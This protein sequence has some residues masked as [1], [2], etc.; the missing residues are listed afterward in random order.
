MRANCYQTAPTRWHMSYARV[1]TG[2]IFI[3][4]HQHDSGE[5]SHC[6][7]LLSFVQCMAIV[8]FLFLGQETNGGERKPV[9]IPGPASGFV[10]IT[11]IESRLST[12]THLTGGTG[13]SRDRPC[14]EGVSILGN[15]ALPPRYPLGQDGAG[16]SRR[17]GSQR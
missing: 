14:A 8:P 11:W 1:P 13:T 7:S 3:W 10:S 5:D 16:P 6:V 9:E 12:R 15:L 4:S 17:T 2:H